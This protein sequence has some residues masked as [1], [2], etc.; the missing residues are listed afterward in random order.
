[1]DPKIL[2]LIMGTPKK[3]PLILGKPQM[4]CFVGFPPTPGSWGGLG[5]LKSLGGHLKKQV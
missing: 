2:I 4:S 1:M 3:V 5:L